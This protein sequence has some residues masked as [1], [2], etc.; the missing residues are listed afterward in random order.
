MSFSN[1]R[2]E[3]PAKK[4]IEW[5]GEK[6]KFFYYD[7]ELNEKIIID[8]PLYFIVLDEFHLI[9]GFDKISK[10]GII[11]NEVRNSQTDLM[12]A[13]SFKGSFNIS[14]IW[15]N[16]KETVTSVGGKYCK[17]VYAMLITKEGNELVNFKFTGSSFSGVTDPEDKYKTIGGWLNVKF[18]KEKYGVTV[19]NSIEG[20]NGTTVYQSPVF[21]AVNIQSRKELIQQAIEMDKVLQDY[22][23]Y[24]L[25]KNNE[26]IIEDE[27]DKEIN[28]KQV[29]E[30]E[31]TI[32][33]EPDYNFSQVR[34][35][36]V[37]NDI[38]DE[39]DDLP[40]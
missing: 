9:T 28:E 10:S 12:N 29:L 14:G 11:S 35:N 23:D 34:E 16:I 30:K 27:I 26:H 15:K 4:F 2:K 7:K 17:S 38:M 31:E 39:T 1:P 5:S 36:A 24:C 18:N 37:N 20:K 19:K 6:A 21:E 25:T 40:F 3:N 32:D 22:M 8:I 33:K 13:R